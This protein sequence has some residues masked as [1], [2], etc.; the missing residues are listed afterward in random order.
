[1]NRRTR[2]QVAADHRKQHNDEENREE[3][4]LE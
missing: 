4:G 3:D 2:G 1:M